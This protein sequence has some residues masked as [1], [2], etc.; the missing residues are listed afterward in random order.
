M[1]AKPDGADLRSVGIAEKTILIVS[2]AIM[3]AIVVP[4]IAATP[5]FAGGFKAPTRERSTCR[6]GLHRRRSRP[7]G[8]P[9]IGG[10]SS[11]RPPSRLRPSQAGLA[12]RVRHER[13]V[14]T[15]PGRRP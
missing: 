3:L 4:T 10:L 6:I 11:R 2:L 13:A 7:T 8:S 9:L 12:R 14:H 5:A 1:P 15:I